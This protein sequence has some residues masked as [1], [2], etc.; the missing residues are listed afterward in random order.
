[1]REF[2]VGTFERH[3][4]ALP[5]R[6][7]CPIESTDH[8]ANVNVAGLYARG[9]RLILLDV[10]NTVTHWRSEEIAAEVRDWIAQAKQLGFAVCIL[11]NT[12]H[13]KRLYRLAES[14]DVPALR[15]PFKPRR[16]MYLEALEKFGV[17]SDAAIMV[18]DQLLTDVLGANRSGI[19]AIWVQPM[20]V[21]EFKGTKI[22]RWIERRLVWWL[23][24]AM[25]VPADEE[26][27][28]PAIERGK[29]FFERTIVKQ[30]VRFLIVGGTSFVIDAGLSYVL[31]TKVSFHGHLISPEI[32]A[33][34]L[35]LAPGLRGVSWFQDGATAGTTL[36]SAFASLVAILNSFYF[37]R[38]WTFE[39]HGPEERLAQLRRFFVVAIIGYLIQNAVFASLTARS[40]I[41]QG[42]GVILVKV[43]AAAIA[44]FWNFLGQ[45]LYAFR[46]KRR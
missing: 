44:A 41:T 19:E 30:V 15:G 33:R 7:F 22:S 5:L 6:P 37:N 29:P 11:S 43:P 1:M 24:N 12:R 34:V 13:P 32:G 38:R 26:A 3:R 27:D 42:P 16:G 45:R 4:V 36:M 20:G 17:D 28:A 31:T 39:T 46:K 35:E 23:Y 10:D 25:A 21:R 2:R 40:H 8:V 18:G 14:L 9:K